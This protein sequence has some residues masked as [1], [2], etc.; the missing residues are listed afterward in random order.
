MKRLAFFLFSILILSGCGG[1]GG[2]GDDEIRV[3]LQV[4]LSDTQ[5]NDANGETIRVTG[6]GVNFTCAQNPTQA[7]PNDT[8]KCEATPQGGGSLAISLTFKSL[9]AENDTYTF[10]DAGSTSPRSGECEV[11]IVNSSRLESPGNTVTDNNT[12]VVCDQIGSGSPNQLVL[13]I[14]L[15]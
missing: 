4:L 5:S 13:T 8:E 14:S 7:E 12:R 15:S 9:R 11:T 3:A 1:G 6:S 2:R 10:S